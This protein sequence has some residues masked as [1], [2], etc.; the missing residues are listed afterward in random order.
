MTVPFWE[1]L[2][3]SGSGGADCQEEWIME[4]LKK[5]ALGRT[6]T[7]F[8]ARTT[9]R[10]QNS[11]EQVF[12]PC[13]MRDA[14]AL[15]GFIPIGQQSSLSLCLCAHMYPPLRLLPGW[16]GTQHKWSLPQPA[17]SNSRLARNDPHAHA[18]PAAVATPERRQ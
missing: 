14:S 1:L 16:L 17:K 8:S 15:Y 10:A 11:A 7:N 4:V 9:E 18:V 5:T 13:A 3:V 12:P 6:T 2:T